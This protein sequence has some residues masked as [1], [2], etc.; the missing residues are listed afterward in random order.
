LN[1]DRNDGADTGVRISI[2]SVSVR[3]AGHLILDNVDL[4]IEPGDHLAIVGPSGAGKS[5]LAGLLLGWHKPA[6]GRILIGDELLDNARLEQLRGQ[7]AWVDPA[8]QLW[9]RSLIEN[10]RYGAPDEAVPLGSVIEA[11]DL[12]RV[13]EKLPDGFQTPLGEGGSLLSGGEGQRVRLGRAM[14]RQKARLVI[15]DEAF[16]GLDRERRHLLLDRARNLWS[17]TTLICITHDVG[18]A[19]NFDRVIV[20]DGGRVVEDGNPNDL[21]RQPRS[22]YRD[23]LEAEE[24]VREGLWS[25][26]EWRRIRLAD[27]VIIEEYKRSDW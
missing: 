2:E 27:G 7:T 15:L 8:V 4:I 5:S 19:G 1:N 22:R 25:S 9:N 17:D 16:R 24:A 10:L 12:R 23:L 20:I 11:A 14:L 6:S 13:L 3:A 21:I 26:D 18:E